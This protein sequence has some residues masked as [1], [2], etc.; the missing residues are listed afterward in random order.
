MNLVF[1]SLLDNHEF[2]LVFESNKFVLFKNRIGD[3]EFILDI[4][5]KSRSNMEGYFSKTRNTTADSAGL[6][7][8]H[9]WLKIPHVYSPHVCKT[10]QILSIVMEELIDLSKVCNKVL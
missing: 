3:D 1:R 5:N 2:Q 10:Y 7:I 8:S 9:T 6:L 4:V